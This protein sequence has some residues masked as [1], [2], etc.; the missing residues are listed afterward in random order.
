MEMRQQQQTFGNNKRESIMKRIMND[1]LNYLYQHDPNFDFDNRHV[2]NDTNFKTK[3]NKH[4]IK[5]YYE[6]QELE[7]EEVK[8]DS[9]NNSYKSDD[10]GSHPYFGSLETTQRKSD[11]ADKRPRRKMCSDYNL[12]KCAD[13][14]ICPARMKPR[15]RYKLKEVCDNNDYDVSYSDFEDNKIL[16]GHGAFGEVYLVCC[17]LNYCKYALK[18]LNKQKVKESGYERHIMREKDISN[19]LDHPNIVRLESYFHD[20]DNCY[21]VFE[22]CRVGDLSTF[23]RDNKK[24]NAKVTREFTMEI[25]NALEYLRKHNVVHRD[26]KPH[27]ILLDDTFHI[28]LADFGAAKVIDPYLVDENLRNLQFYEGENNSDEEYELDSN[29]SVSDSSLEEMGDLEK[30]QI[31]TTLYISPEMLRYQQACF[32][33][34]LWALG[35]IIYE[36]LVGKP[37]F[38]GKNKYE[39][40]GKILRGEFKFPRKFNKHAKDLIRRLLKVVPSERLGAGHDNSENSLEEL[41]AHPF[42]KGK[43]FKRRNKKVPSIKSLRGGIQWNKYNDYSDAYTNEENVS[44]DDSTSSSVRSMKFNSI[45]HIKRISEKVYRSCDRASRQSVKREKSKFFKELA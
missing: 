21:F 36:C 13:N 38:L 43:N 8:S 18:I 11:N 30:T 4:R 25:I 34:D 33:S 41:K 28:K 1:A 29:S 22:L 5:R 31:G 10:K 14:A 37:P 19:I 32:A 45:K 26:L 27:N 2:A 35:C 24:L 17:K 6:E 15:P 16:L 3:Q 20:S 44:E 42:F 12:T 40:E 9:L 39:V 7:Q 23:I